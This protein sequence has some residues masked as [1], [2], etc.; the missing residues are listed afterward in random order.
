MRQSPFSQVEFLTEETAVKRRSKRSLENP[1]PIL[2]ACAHLLGGV[3]TTIM[4][5]DLPE[6]LWALFR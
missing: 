6:D 5:G 3:G 4:Y 1:N 2:V